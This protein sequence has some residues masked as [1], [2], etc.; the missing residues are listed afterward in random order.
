MSEQ[1]RD[2]EAAETFQNRYNKHEG[3]IEELLWNFIRQLLGKFYSGYN[4]LY[5]KNL[6]HGKATPTGT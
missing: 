6:R 1:C 4:Y 5:R 2:N 3:K